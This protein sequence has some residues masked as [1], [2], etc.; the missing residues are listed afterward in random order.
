MQRAPPQCLLHG[1]K[2][3]GKAWPDSVTY[4]CKETDNVSDR[5]KD[6]PSMLRDWSTKSSWLQG[7]WKNAAS[8]VSFQMRECV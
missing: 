7:L 2:W 6:A 8:Q 1:R 5:E 3:T 4:V